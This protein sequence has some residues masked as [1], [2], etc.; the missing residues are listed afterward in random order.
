M[1]IPPAYS[2]TPIILE[3]I[4]KIEANRIYLN[5][6]NLRPEIKNRIQRISLLK[7]SLFSARIE[8][9]PLTLDDVEY[10]KDLMRKREVNNILQAITYIDA[11]IYTQMKITTA[12]MQ[13][14]HVLVMNHIDSGAGNIRH[15]VSGIFNSA[16]VVVYMPPA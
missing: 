9:N 2:L 4:T 13:K 16:G 10:T 12:I 6:L 8:G 14:L 7:S 1:K 5:S 15:E 11:P 3:L